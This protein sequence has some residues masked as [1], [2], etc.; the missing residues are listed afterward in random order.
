MHLIWTKSGSANNH[1]SL[2]RECKV[3]ETSAPSKSCFNPSSQWFTTTRKIQLEP[4]ELKTHL[5]NIFQST[6]LTK[7]KWFTLEGTCP[8]PKGGHKST[9]CRESKTS[10]KTRKVYFVDF[11]GESKQNVD[12]CGNGLQLHS[13]SALYGAAWSASRSGYLTHPFNED[14]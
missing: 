11:W 12:I 4:T 7:K 9:T 10:K 1:K 8:Q 6:S 2:L 13:K 5:N 14:G 3:R